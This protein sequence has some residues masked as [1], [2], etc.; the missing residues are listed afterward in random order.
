MAI[1]RSIVIDGVVTS[2]SM[3]DIF[4][5]EVDRRAR[6]QG[7]P[8]QDFIRRMLSGVQ[9][10]PNRSAA[11][12]ETLLRQLRE[13]ASRPQQDKFETWWKVRTP[14]GH[15]EVGTRGGRLVVGR[16]A[17]CDI[18]V[19][20]REVSRRHL[21]LA[22]DG[23]TWWATDLESKNGTWLQGSRVQAV[24]LKKGMCLEIGNSLLMF[25]N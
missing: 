4:W 24:R 2:L 10:V 18:V 19:D 1:K 6:Q 3:E 12:R 8:W 11:V 13:E 22:F 17:V 21:L 15:R 20:D 5:E 14:S 7:L 9:N 23:E 25:L 16:S